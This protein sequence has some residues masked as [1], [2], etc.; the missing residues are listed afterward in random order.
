M[1][2]QNC[3]LPYRQRGKQAKPFFTQLPPNDCQLSRPRKFNV[4]KPNLDHNEAQ[5]MTCY[6]RH[7]KTQFQ[8]AGITVT[9]ENKKQ[10]DNTIRTII[11]KQATT[12][13][14]TWKEVKKR[15]EQSE[16][17]FITELKNAW[18]NRKTQP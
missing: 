3:P 4:R 17:A 14:T 7:L 5:G 1:C 18:N 16:D 10:I 11:G 13:P 15:L 8:K 12:C 9:A 2:F 6:F